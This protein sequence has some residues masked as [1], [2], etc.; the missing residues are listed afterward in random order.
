MKIAVLTKNR[1]NPAYAA[2]RSG[3]DAVAAELGVRIAHYVPDQPDDPEEQ[4]QLIEQAMQDSA[5]AIV[6]APV[7]A[8]RVGAALRRA[9]AAGMPLFGFVSSVPEVMWVSFVGSD[10][11]RLAKALALR[12]FREMS[13]QGD[14][15]VIDGSTESQ[16]GLDRARGFND[17]LH[18]SNGIRVVTRCNGQYRRDTA[19]TECAALLAQ[20]PSV[21]AVLAANDMMA[22]GAVDALRAARR[23]ALVAGVNAIPEA[24]AAIKDG[25]MIATADFNA[26]QL[27]A[28]AV[29][30]AIRHLR[31]ERMP[32]GIQL[33]VRIVDRDNVQLWDLPFEKRP[34]MRWDEVLAASGKIEAHDGGGAA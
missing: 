5:D 12:L 2:A 14:V 29:E 24:I 28:T 33:P 27:A 4:A 31:G 7:L 1:I 10:D 6:A 11:R 13:G 8:P 17:A 25:T 34:R 22:L 19:R 30:C 18:S 3:A 20:K 32:A 23:T 16:T 9:S 15:I 26:M 21:D